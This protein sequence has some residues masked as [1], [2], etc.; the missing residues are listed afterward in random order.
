MYYYSNCVMASSCLQGEIN[1]EVVLL[2][3]EE[4]RKLVKSKILL[5][6]RAL[7]AVALIICAIVLAPEQPEEQ[8]YICQKYNPIEAC[9]LL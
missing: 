9:L 5:N 8:A 7:M 2:P 3:K 1:P 4:L 6:W